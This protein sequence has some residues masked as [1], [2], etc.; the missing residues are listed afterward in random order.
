MMEKRFYP[1][2]GETLYQGKLQNGLQIIVL[3]RPGFTKKL[4][5]FVTDYGAIHTHFQ[6][7]GA[8]Y[9]APAGVAHYLE[10]KLFDMPG[11][12]VTGEFAAMGAIPNAFT[13]YDMTAYYVL[14]SGH[15]YESLQILLEFVSTPY[16]PEESIKRELGIIDQEIGMHTDSPESRVFENLMQAMYRDFP[17]RLPI[18]GTSD[19]IR[20]ITPEILTLCHQAF[21]DPSNMVL[22]IVGD[23]D[24]KQV[25][26]LV[27]QVLGTQSRTAGEKIRVET[28]PTTCFQPRITDKMEISMPTFLLGFKWGDLENSQE[29]IRLEVIGDLAAEALF[30]ESSQLYLDLY[31]QG[32]IDGSFGG[33]FEI[34]DDRAMLICGGDSNDPQAVFDAILAQAEKLSQTGI[35]ESAFLRMKRSALGRRIRDLDSFDSTCF[36][37]CAYALSEFDYFD[38]PEIYDRISRE[39]I[40]QF[41]QVLTDRARWSISVIDPI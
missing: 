34:A 26:S 10:H 27:Q 32:I 35:E 23:V 21:Y 22:S 1:Q 14:C 16:F 17:I 36:R 38:F 19:S 11:R 41:L 29:S 40:Q 3:P 4:C 9:A 15:F 31:D 30:G 33:G 20:E 24:P 28:E 18:L 8:E 12:D 25:L 2:V 5:Y 39:D 13:S 6:M 37:L 7:D